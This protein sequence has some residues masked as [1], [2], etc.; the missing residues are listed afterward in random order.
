MRSRLAPS[1]R[2]FRALTAIVTVWC[3]GCAG[4]EPLIDALQTDRGEASSSCANEAR[5]SGTDDAQDVGHTRTM[6]VGAAADDHGH[7]G[8]ACGTSCLTTLLS[9]VRVA[10]SGAP[11]PAIDQDVARAPAST[12]RPPLLPPPQQLGA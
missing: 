12:V 7:L 2:V 5:M 3:L 9:P 1:S 8:C 10:G 6:R 11:V 4:F